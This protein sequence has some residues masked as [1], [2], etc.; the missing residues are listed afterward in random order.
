MAEIDEELKSREISIPARPIHAVLEVGK[1][2]RV[3]LPITTK[4]EPANGVFSGEH[5]VA[6]IHRWFDD[7]YGDRL[8]IDFSLGRTLVLIR[9]DPWVVTLPK[10]V[11]AWELVSDPS[12]LSSPGGIRVRG[13]RTTPNVYN[14]LDSIRDLPAGLRRD[15]SDDE[16]ETVLIGFVRAHEAQAILDGLRGKRLVAE[17]RADLE[18]SVGQ[19]VGAGSHLGLA[20]WSAL[21]AAEKS[22]KAFLEDRGVEYPWSHKLRELARLAESHGMRQIERYYLDAASC[23]PGVRYDASGITV[24]E[25]VFAHQ[26]AYEI[27]RQCGIQLRLPDGA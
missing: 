7:R 5:L 3:S 22:L 11:G 9:Q 23:A 16:C 12:I 1:R 13:D 24:D 2:F 20:R 26:A 19:V 18:A 15:L 4:L 6:R 14:V 25:A 27:V 17:I 8:K 10:L 21:Q